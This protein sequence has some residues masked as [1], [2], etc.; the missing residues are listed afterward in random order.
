METSN[1]YSFLVALCREEADD[2]A[3]GSADQF[4]LV[5]TA[6]DGARSPLFTSTF[7]TF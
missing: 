3:P 2:A 4:A 1:A 5:R 6:P 7:H